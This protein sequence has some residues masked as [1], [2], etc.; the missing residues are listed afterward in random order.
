MYCGQHLGPHRSG[1]CT[2][3][4]DYKV[5]LGPFEGEEH[6][7]AKAAA[8]K[9]RTLGLRLYQEGEPKDWIARIKTC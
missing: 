4:L 1:W 8:E 3:G 2:V 5:G 7:Q 9:C 6:Q